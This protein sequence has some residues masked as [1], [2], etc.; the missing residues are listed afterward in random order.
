MRE[1][2]RER[3]L[4]GDR[5]RE[6]DLDLDRDLARECLEDLMLS[7]PLYLRR[8]SCSTPGEELRR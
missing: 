3:V 5:E 1:R 7:D 8:G 6:R 4:E 2:D